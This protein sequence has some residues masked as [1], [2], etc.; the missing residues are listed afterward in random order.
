MSGAFAASLWGKKVDFSRNFKCSLW[1]LDAG[2]A[3]PALEELSVCVSLW[4]RVASPQWTVFVYKQRGDEK[5]QLGLT[6]TTESL[7]VWLF[8]H[9]WAAPVDLPLEVWHVVCLTWSGRSRNLRLYVN[10]TRVLSAH[11]HR[12][13]R[14][15]PGGTLSLGASHGFAGGGIEAETGTGFQGTV[16]LFRMWGRERSPQQ[17]SALS[18]TEG[19]VV[20]WSTRDWDTSGCQPIFDPSLACAWSL[21]EIQVK[22]CVTSWDGSAMNTHAAK[23]IMSDWLGKILPPSMFLYSISVTFSTSFDCMVHVEV[24]PSADVSN[25]QVT[26]SHLLSIQYVSGLLEVTTDTGSIII[27]PVDTFYR[28]TLNVTVSGGAASDPATVIQS[29]LAAVLPVDHM[30]VLNFKLLTRTRSQMECRTPEVGRL[31]LLSTSRYGCTFQAQVNT[32]SDVAQ[33]ERLIRDLLMVYFTSGSLTVHAEPGDIQSLAPALSTV[34]KPDKGSMCGRR[35]RLSARPLSPAKGAL[36]RQAAGTDNSVDVVDMIL[37]FT[38]DHGA[39]SHPELVTVLNKLS[40]VL[41][42]SQVTPP[43]GQAMVDI[44]ADILESDTNVSPVTNLILSIMEDIGDKMSFSGESYNMTAPSLAIALVNID[45]GQFFGITFGVNSASQDLNPEI[46][47]NEDPLKDTVAFISLPPEVEDRFPQHQKTPPRIQFH[48]YGVP[49][50]FKDTQNGKELN[51]YVVSASVT[52]ATISDLEQHVVVTLRHRRPVD[53][54]DEV[55]CVYWNFSENGGFGGWDSSGCSKHNTSADQTTCVCDHLTHFGVLVDLSRAPVSEKDKEILTVISYLGCGI[56][57]VFLGVSLLTYMAFEKL[58]RDYPSKILINLSLALLGLNLVFLV[59]SWLASFGSDGLCISVAALLHYF[60]LASFTWMGLEAVHMYFAL[61]KVFNVYVPSYILKFCVL[62]WGIP[63]VI[64]S[65]ILAVKRD[66]YGSAVNGTSLEPLDDTELFC[67]LQ[68]DVV[69]YVSVVAYII[70]VLLCNVAVFMV[71]LVQIRRVR[72]NKP[73]GGRSGLLHDLRGVA[74]LTFLLGLTWMLIFFAWGPARLTLVYLFSILNSLQGFFIFVFHCLMKE[75]VRKQ[76]R[77][78]L[79]C[80][81]FRLKEHS[82][83][84]QTAT[85]GVKSRPNHLVHT[86]SVKSARSDN[87]N[88]SST[89]SNSSVSAQRLVSTRRSDLELVYENRLPFPRACCSPPSLPQ[90]TGC[91]MPSWP[92]RDRS[93]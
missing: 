57:S 27:H 68:D 8:G 49:Q 47:I 50:L 20:H 62:G 51:T 30:W 15:P 80:G 75:N 10:N 54:K 32:S 74:S 2:C 61:V 76:W 39:L 26:I 36:I 79:C 7:Q 41:E 86:P 37:N 72:A 67:W 33:T 70:L 69:F 45:P 71:V 85:V 73:G 88:S 6:G 3:V 14:L 84:S 93:H 34:S 4:K 53:L 48:F 92:P 58:R 23:E 1:Q 46:F 42:V 17:L 25:V 78:H 65:L 63:L 91:G 9:A 24:I 82:D 55:E 90:E 12:H 16:T 60:L 59:D 89:T 38:R 66:A 77:A 22:V 35:R 83:W 29:W 43:L 18:C 52:N 64:V 28:V 11:V 44:I 21:Y 40:E 31:T 87:S 81:Q 56:S 19:D 13:A 5:A